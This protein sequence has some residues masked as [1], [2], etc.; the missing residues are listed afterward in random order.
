MRGSNLGNI[1]E[2][3]VQKMNFSPLHIRNDT[4]LDPKQI[5]VSRLY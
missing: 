2:I 3:T 5:K 1:G 4:N